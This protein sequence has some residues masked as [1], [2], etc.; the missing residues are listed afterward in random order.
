M[1]YT[2]KNVGIQNEK[3]G[4]SCSKLQF[5]WIIGDYF[6]KKCIF[7]Q[8]YWSFVLKLQKRARDK[9]ASYFSFL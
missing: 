7:L 2:T 3:K 1:F 6:V 4:E 5:F 8:F 9:Y